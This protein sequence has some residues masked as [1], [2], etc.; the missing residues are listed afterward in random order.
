[1]LRRQKRYM[2]F[3]SVPCGCRDVLTEMLV[4]AEKV[5]RDLEKGNLKARVRESIPHFQ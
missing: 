3:V 5:A 1:M 2:T 4:R